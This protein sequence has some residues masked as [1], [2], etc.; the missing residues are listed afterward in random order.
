MQVSI[1]IRITEPLAMNS[2]PVFAILAGLS[3][4]SVSANTDSKNR[5]KRQVYVPFGPEYL[6]P[7]NTLV[8]RID[9]GFSKYLLQFICNQ[10]TFEVQ[11]TLCRRPAIK[12]HARLLQDSG[13]PY[14]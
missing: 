2:H 9:P 8:Y 13:N 3:V 14:R 12:A 6:W 10:V 4:I 11:N 5:P 1:D 7:K